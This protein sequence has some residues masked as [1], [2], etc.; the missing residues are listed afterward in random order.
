MGLFLRRKASDRKLEKREKKNRKKWFISKKGFDDTLSQSKT[1]KPNSF[2]SFVDFTLLDPRATAR[3]IEDLCYIAYKNQYYAVIVPPVFVSLAKRIIESKYSGAIKVGSVVG[4]PLGNSLSKSKIY[5]TKMLIKEG[6]DEID[7]S[8]SVSAVK[9]SEYNLIKAELSRIVRIA[10]KKVVKAI[11]ETSYL[12][13]QEIERL[14][15]IAIK[16][17]CD[18]VMTSSG[19]A[20]LGANIE[21]VEKLSRFADGK[22]G[23]KASG[24]VKTKLEAESFLRLGASR[25]GTSRIL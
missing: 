18:F 2:G 19:Y 17:K 20:P 16:A 1:N 15:K 23:I 14:V 4:F 8:I 25:I 13:E 21:L 10:K 24:G 9:M 11:I 5:D 6:A 12:T 22:I 7:V 3:D